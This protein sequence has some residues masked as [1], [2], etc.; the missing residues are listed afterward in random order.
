LAAN[1]WNTASE[2]TTC[3]RQ[4]GINIC[5]AVIFIPAHL[6]IIDNGLA[7]E[8]IVCNGEKVPIECLAPWIPCPLEQLRNFAVYKRLDDQDEHNHVDV[9]GKEQGW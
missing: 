1:G 5:S 7:V 2:N 9:T 4:F 8:V 6:E 3:Y